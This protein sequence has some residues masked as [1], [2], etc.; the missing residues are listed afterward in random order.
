MH[1][2]LPATIA[3]GGGGVVG[4]GGGGSRGEDGINSGGEGDALLR[5][6]VQRAIGYGATFIVTPS[7]VV[8]GS[9]ATTKGPPARQVHLR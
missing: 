4:G 6:A 3:S 5:E 9:H 8:E 7:H 1:C 2:L